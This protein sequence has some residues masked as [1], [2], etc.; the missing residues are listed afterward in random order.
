MREE[1]YYEL[2][3]KNDGSQQCVVTYAILVSDLVA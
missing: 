3:L 2:S 1:K